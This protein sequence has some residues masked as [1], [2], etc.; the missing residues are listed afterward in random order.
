[1]RQVQPETLPKNSNFSSC[2]QN[3]YLKLYS[4]KLWISCS[5]RSQW[6][7]MRSGKW[8]K[9]RCYSLWVRDFLFHCFIF[10]WKKNRL[11]VY[12]SVF[13]LFS[14]CIDHFI[15]YSRI[16]YIGDSL[17]HVICLLG[18]FPVGSHSLGHMICLLIYFRLAAMLLNI[19]KCMY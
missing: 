7:R 19:L 3:N 8:L 18:L 16:V 9:I 1:M 11:E 5:R 14:R 12:C 15:C 2:L 17:G 13:L 6:M 4:W 10:I